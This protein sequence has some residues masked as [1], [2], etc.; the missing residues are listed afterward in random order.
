MLLLSAFLAIVFVTLV[1]LLRGFGGLCAAALVGGLSRA[2]DSGPLEAWFVDTTRAADPAAR[3]DRGLSLSG[4]LDGVALAVGAVAGGFLPQFFSGRLSTPLIA[5]LAFHGV[6][7]VAVAS[8]MAERLDTS[9][10]AFARISTAFRQIPEV[11]RAGTASALRSTCLRKLLLAALALGFGISAVEVLWQPRFAAL[12]G[13]RAS[14]TGFFGVLLAMAFGASGLGALAS[15]WLRRTLRGHGSLA[16]TT[17]Q[18]LTGL[19]LI[20]LALQREPVGA[21][22]LFVA[23]YFFMGALGPLLHGLLHEYVAP[24]RRATMLSANSLSL[25]TGAFASSI[26]VP[27]LAGAFGIPAA[28]IMA[29]AVV[30]L[31]GVIFVRVPE[32]APASRSTG[33]AEPLP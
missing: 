26:S 21:A 4:T 12:L 23:T 11:L 30:S 22:A 8:F 9:R 15:P 24:E 14:A 3:L 28:W 13:A 32:R 19:S 20:A 25:Q 29:G 10:V 17:T 18:A 33:V 7:F 27:A 5:A 6:H 2:L 16:V 31:V 1:L